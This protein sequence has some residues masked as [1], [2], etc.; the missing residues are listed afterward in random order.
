LE[1]I[2]NAVDR[3]KEIAARYRTGKGVWF[4]VVEVMKWHPTRNSGEVTGTFEMRCEGR[5]AA[6]LAARQML[7]EEVALL[8]DD[9][10]VEA[11]VKC[12]LEW[13]MV[14]ER[15]EMVSKAQ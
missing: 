12:D 1:G 2:A 4:A 11:S 10:I 3:K 14:D 5:K 13:P 6:V 15:T 7:A 8:S 9:V